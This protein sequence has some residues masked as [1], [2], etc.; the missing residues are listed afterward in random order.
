MARRGWLAR[1]VII[2][3]I[4]ASHIALLM[5]LLYVRPRVSGTPA[6]SLPATTTLRFIDVASTR[7]A[8]SGRPL[9]LDT[10][11]APKRVSP[12]VDRSVAQRQLAASTQG[13]EKDRRAVED[14]FLDE[15]A[16]SADVPLMPGSK[17]Y[18]EGGGFL[19]GRSSH[20]ESRQARLPGGAFVKGAPR[21]QMV[22]PR[23]QGLA[24]VVRLIGSV[25][26]AVDKHCIDLD[27]WQGM[28]P[29]ERIAHHV[30]QAD[31]A[32]AREEHGCMTGSNGRSTP[33]AR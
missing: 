11:K 29:E 4:S 31:V 19:Q 28:T 24:G 16:P 22:D 12:S 26:G 3:V 1:G 13:A 25:T 20:T 15:R 23:V 5:G 8:A 33:I 32:R 27:A 14:E 21:L 10:P 18:I 30:S 7:V 2:G 9:R 17:Q 6:D